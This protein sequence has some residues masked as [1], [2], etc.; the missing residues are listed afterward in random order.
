MGE[1]NQK[2]KVE[3]GQLIDRLEMA[4]NKFKERKEKDKL[5]YGIGQGINGGI[6]MPEDLV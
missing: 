6:D 4:L 2:L 1:I 3:L 5:R